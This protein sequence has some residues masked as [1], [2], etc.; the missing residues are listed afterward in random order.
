MHLMTS[1]PGSEIFSG[2]PGYCPC[3]VRGRGGYMGKRRAEGSRSTA[4][5][6]PYNG[7]IRPSMQ[8]EESPA[9]ETGLE[10]IAAK[11][12]GAPKLRF[13]SL[14]H[15]ITRERVWENLCEIRTDSA[16]EWM[17]KWCR[18]LSRTPVPILRNG[19]DLRFQVAPLTD[20]TVNFICG[21][22]GIRNCRS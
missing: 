5:W 10:R 12:Q 22:A 9:M 6:P 7:R 18:R 21:Q 4:T 1:K 15:H 17:G 16:R 20:R 3:D 13:T 19:P 14:A 8:R 2:R 11:A